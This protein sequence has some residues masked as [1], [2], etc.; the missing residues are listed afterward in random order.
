ML[1][2]LSPAAPSAFLIVP[3]SSLDNDQNLKLLFIYMTINKTHGLSQ[4]IYRRI[5]ITTKK[6]S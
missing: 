1:Q 5:T 2:R 3:A 4:R 6:T